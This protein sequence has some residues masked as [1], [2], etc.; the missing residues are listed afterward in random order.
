[1]EAQKFTKKIFYLH[2]KKGGR[3]LL[4]FPCSQKTLDFRLIKTGRRSVRLIGM[5][6]MYSWAS[7]KYAINSTLL[8]DQNHV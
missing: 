5:I 8:R 4:Y 7:I 6:Y 1:M 3:E 2:E